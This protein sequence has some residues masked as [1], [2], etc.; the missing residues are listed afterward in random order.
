MNLVGKIFIVLIFLM[1]LVFM[2]LAVAV[3]S[4]HTNWRDA[5]ENDDPSKGALGLKP[6]LE[7]AQEEIKVLLDLV[8]ETKENAETERQQQRQRQQQL[9]TANVELRKARDDKDAALTE[10]QRQVTEATNTMNRVAAR[11]E[12]LKA[13]LEQKRAQI[14][15]VT[16]EKNK[17]RM[18]VVRLTDEVHQLAN[19]LRRLEGMRMALAAD[20][21]RMR[22]LLEVNDINP[23]AD[24]SVGV[25]I[26]DGL[27]SKPPTKDGLVEVTVGEDDGIRK[28]HLLDVFHT[29]DGP[30]KYM[31]RLTVVNTQY[32]KAVCQI[33][34]D[35][36]R[37]PIQKDDY[38]VTKYE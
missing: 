37:G 24:P 20:A 32:D 34:P 1:S 27:V 5:V 12:D 17:D 30:T 36:L 26:V 23:A 4:A 13:E 15:E 38:V 6:Q 8:E 22:K 7:D 28:G 25:P 29:G 18:E 10:A 33:I 31:G 11:L 16:D 3:Y 35:T 2:A 9:E 21:V 19:E 14:R